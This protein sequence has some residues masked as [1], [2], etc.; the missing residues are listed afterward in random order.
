MASEV[1]AAEAPEQKLQ[2]DTFV[3]FELAV[4]ANRVSQMIGN[5][6]DQKFNLLVPDWRILVTL[7]RCGPLSPNEIAEKTA[8][9]KARVSRAQRRLI[10]LA[11]VSIADD[12][13]DG[14]R[15][16]LTLEPLG[17]KVCRGMIPEAL[18]QQ[19]Y[20]LECLTA[21]EATALRDILAKL[22]AHTD[23]PVV[24]ESG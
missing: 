22:H 7:H 10:D 9:D 6:I 17:R 18:E 3:P 15:K 16:V 12:P 5:L 21:A 23:H 2:L 1:R 24:A 11:L 20:L 4:V 13:D 19:R 14:R 8:M